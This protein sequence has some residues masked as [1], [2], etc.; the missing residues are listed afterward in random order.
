MYRDPNDLERAY[1]GTMGN[2]HGEFKRSRCSM[3]AH[4][5][6]KVGGTRASSG[7]AKNTTLSCP[8]VAILQRLIR[9]EQYLSQHKPNVLI[10]E[11]KPGLPLDSCLP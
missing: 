2:I 7:M 11:V 6:E 3:L 1:S 5:I 10:C 4:M 8:M 9:P